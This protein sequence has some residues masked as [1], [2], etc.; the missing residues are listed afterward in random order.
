MIIEAARW[1]LSHEPIKENIWNNCNHDE[2]NTS[3]AVYSSTS[4]IN[5]PHGSAL[6]S[7]ESDFSRTLECGME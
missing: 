5:I 7:H 4:A 2:R 1:A 3:N 6:T